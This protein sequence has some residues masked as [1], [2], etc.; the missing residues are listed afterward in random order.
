MFLVTPVSPTWHIRTAVSPSSTR[1]GFSG[2]I[3]TRGK[4]KQNFI[5]KGIGSS[6]QN[7]IFLWIW[8]TSQIRQKNG[9]N[10]ETGLNFETLNSILSGKIKWVKKTFLIIIMFWLGTKAVVPWKPPCYMISNYM[11]KYNKHVIIT[12]FTLLYVI[13]YSYVIINSL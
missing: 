2:P 10:W 13:I 11:N 8:A 5:T 4:S 12:L 6:P 9:F 3:E 1:S 7:Q